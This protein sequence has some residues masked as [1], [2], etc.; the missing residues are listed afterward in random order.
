MRAIAGVFALAVLAAGSWTSS[1]QQGFFWGRG[2]DVVRFS[3]P[4]GNR[5]ATANTII[6]GV[7]AAVLPNGRLV[8]PAG[9]EVNVST[10]TSST[11]PGL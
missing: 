11:G 1:A 3:A 2:F 8:T 5:P 10:S 6:D 4:A 7:S 9:T